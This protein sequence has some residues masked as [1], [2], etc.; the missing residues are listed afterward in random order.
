MN[1]T[2]GIIMISVQFFLGETRIGF[3]VVALV[4]YLTTV[5]HGVK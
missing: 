1:I 2:F 5:F 3:E 4:Q